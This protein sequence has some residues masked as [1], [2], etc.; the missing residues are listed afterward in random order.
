M[1]VIMAV[2]VQK[3]VTSAKDGRDFKV[4]RR[5]EEMEMK[6]LNED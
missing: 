1:L 3:A 5:L 4:Y 6:V 2:T